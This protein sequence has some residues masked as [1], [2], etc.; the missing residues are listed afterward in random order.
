[1]REQ[2]IRRIHVHLSINRKLFALLGDQRNSLATDATHSGREWDGASSSEME[3]LA[4]GGDGYCIVR[5]RRTRRKPCG[6]PFRVRRRNIELPVFRPR[7][8]NLADTLAK[9]LAYPRCKI[10]R[11]R[12]P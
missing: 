4:R 7:V 11:R 8:N 2:V 9:T 12:R 3:R 1:M 5:R 10:V 6:M